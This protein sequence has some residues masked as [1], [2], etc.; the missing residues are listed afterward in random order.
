ME[1]WREH[2]QELQATEGEE[3]QPKTTS[4]NTDAVNDKDDK[5]ITMEELTKS[6]Q[7][8]KVDKAPGYDKIT[9]EMLTHKEIFLQLLNN[10][11]RDNKIAEDWKLAVILPGHKK[12]SDG[13]TEK[14]DGKGING[15][16]N[17]FRG[18]TDGVF[19]IKQLTYQEGVRFSG[20]KTLLENAGKETPHVDGTKRTRSRMELEDM[21]RRAEEKE[22]IRQRRENQNG[23]NNEY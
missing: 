9:A 11:T 22:I 4:E 5:T 23:G 3:E 14:R 6:L 1:R 18:T 15:K 20:Q 12:Y 16:Q 19:V 17:G 8:L 10:I 13:N 7:K 21:E 2:L